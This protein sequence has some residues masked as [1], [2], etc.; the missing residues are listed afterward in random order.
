MYPNYYLLTVVL[1]QFYHLQ[2]NIVNNSPI[3]WPLAANHDLYQ[4]MNKWMNT[5]I[6]DP[7]SFLCHILYI[8]H[9]RE[10]S[11]QS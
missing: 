3:G 6:A 5:S 9:H 11:S 4:T 1:V 10:R 2:Y 8:Y 7:G